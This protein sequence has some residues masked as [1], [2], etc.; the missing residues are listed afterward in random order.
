VLNLDLHLASRR[1]ISLS[2][3]TDIF[4]Q[5]YSH[6][7]EDK[8]GWKSVFVAG[9][10]AGGNLAAAVAIKNRDL[11]QPVPIAA[12]ALL[13]PCLLRPSH[14]PLQ[15]KDLLKSYYSNEN[16]PII[17]AVVM[18]KFWDYYNPPAH[19]Y[20]SPLLQ[21]SLQ[22]LPPA[23]VLVAGLDPLQD[24]GILYAKLLARAGVPVRTREWPGFPHA[25]YL[26]P[27]MQASRTVLSELVEALDTLL[28]RTL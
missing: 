20:G 12:Q 4:C 2:V 14:I 27:T 28:S 22:N 25:F 15:F 17:N 21:E 8:A 26:I 6:A 24:E 7:G 10:S 19:S 1:S 3:L 11:G 9:N 13:V 16:S 18:D 23:Y 5:G